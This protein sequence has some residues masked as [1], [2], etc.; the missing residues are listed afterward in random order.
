MLVFTRDG[1]KEVL[2]GGESLGRNWKWEEVISFTLPPGDE[3]LEVETAVKVLGPL[4]LHLG[5]D[6]SFNISLS[7]ERFTMWSRSR[8]E[9]WPWLSLLHLPLHTT[10]QGLLQTSGLLPGLSLHASALSCI[11]VPNNEI[12]TVH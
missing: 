12:M 10:V 4:E 1:V 7:S 9:L 3:E 6:W 8:E 5:Q 11:R 2:A